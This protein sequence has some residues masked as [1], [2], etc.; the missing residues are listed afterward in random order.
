M[1]SHRTIRED[2]Q[3]CLQINY[4]LS[5]NRQKMI[6][7]QL[8]RLEEILL[9]STTSLMKD[10]SEIRMVAIAINLEEGKIIKIKMN[11]SS[12]R[13]MGKNSHQTITIKMM[14]RMRGNTMKRINTVMSRVSRRLLYNLIKLMKGL[15]LL[16]LEDR[17]RIE[18]STIG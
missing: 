13:V 15:L 9:R 7:R 16:L 12:I 11:R 14:V 1:R 5:N 18:I 10:H 6:H 2:L 17:K 3:L 8:F 4:L